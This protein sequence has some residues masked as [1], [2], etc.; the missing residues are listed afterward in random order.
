M[1]IQLAYK[2][3]GEDAEKL[4][5]ILKNITEILGNR[6]Y[7]VYC[8][9]LDDSKPAEENEILSHTFKLIDEA[10]VLLALLSS[11][12]KSEGMLM[13]IG[14]AVAKNKKIVTAIKK[15]IGNTRVK[16]TS[17]NIIE[18]ENNDDLYGKL[19]GFEF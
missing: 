14:Y 19:K 18:F 8:P 13:E 1:K 4:M 11:D 10:D 2:F 3:T 9:V 16:D 12:E 15:D 7:E 17:H 6:G 5:G